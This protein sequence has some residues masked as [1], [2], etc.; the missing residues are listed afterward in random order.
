MPEQM[1]L[2]DMAPTTPAAVRPATHSEHKVSPPHE[3]M[4]R[5]RERI[6]GTPGTIERA[7]D[8]HTARMSDYGIPVR[9]AAP[10]L[11]KLSP[12]DT[13]TWRR[14]GQYAEMPLHGNDALPDLGTGQRDVSPTRIAEIERSPSVADDPRFPGRE[15]PLV[16]DVGFQRNGRTQYAPVLHNGNHRVAAATS[17]QLFIDVSYIPKER[18]PEAVAHARAKRTQ[19]KD[20]RWEK[21]DLAW[22]RLERRDATFRY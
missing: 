9:G 13:S 2:F 17:Q 8:I 6:A 15:R 19:F 22:Q 14:F 12:F 10:S 20:A 18:L 4:L 21:D 7:D 3:K 16:A 11:S 5:N 1:R